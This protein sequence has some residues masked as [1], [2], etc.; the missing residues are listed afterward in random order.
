MGLGKHYNDNNDDYK[1]LNHFTMV[2]ECQYPICMYFPSIS[3]YII[4]A[5]KYRLQ[6]MTIAPNIYILHTY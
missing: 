4:S 6:S 5:Q 3:N 2:Y 1:H